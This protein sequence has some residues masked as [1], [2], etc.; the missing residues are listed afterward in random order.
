M[1]E[2]RRTRRVAEV[3]PHSTA[4]G[5][6]LFW[7]LSFMYMVCVIYARAPCV[8]YPQGPQEDPLGL[9]LQTVVSLHV[10]AQNQTW[11]L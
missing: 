9:E 10:G 1:V 5:L 3:R 11:P 8:Q 2:V 7:K 6:F 4:S